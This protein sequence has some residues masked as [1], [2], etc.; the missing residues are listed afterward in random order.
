MGSV[1]KASSNGFEWVEVNTSQFKRDFIKCHIKK[2]MKDIFKDSIQ[3]TKKLHDL[4][5]DLPFLSERM[6]IEKFK[7]LAV[8]LHDKTDMLFSQET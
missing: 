6:K 5:N 1:A 4:H 3:Y 2:V 7:K 8:N